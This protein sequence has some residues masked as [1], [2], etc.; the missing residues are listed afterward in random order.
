M[1]GEG[2]N[3]GAVHRGAKKSQFTSTRFLVSGGRAGCGAVMAMT[4]VNSVSLNRM[5]S[6]LTGTVGS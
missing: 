1:R 3:N 4:S 2:G 6:A 5:R